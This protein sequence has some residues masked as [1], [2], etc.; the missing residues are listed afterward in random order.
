M[1]L[2]TNAAAMSLYGVSESER[3]GGIRQTPRKR[4]DLRSR[5]CARPTQLE[6]SQYRA[7]DDGTVAA[8]GIITRDI[9]L[10]KLVTYF[11]NFEGSSC[12]RANISVMSKL[13]RPRET[14]MIQVESGRVRSGNHRAPPVAKPASDERVTCPIPRLRLRKASERQTHMGSWTQISKL[15]LNGWQLSRT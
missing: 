13:M 8:I 9:P 1:Y 6:L 11:W 4:G 3:V 5:L 14:G 2:A 12:L 7:M 15:A 10:I